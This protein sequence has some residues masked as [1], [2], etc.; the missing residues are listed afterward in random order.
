MR[1]RILA[2][3]INL[4][5]LGFLCAETGS[6]DK[7]RFFEKQV[8]PLLVKRCLKCHS[9]KKHKGSVRLDSRKFLL[10]GNESGPVVVPGKPTA[11]RMI[12]VL[13]YSKDDIQMP[14][15]G[16]LPRKEIDILRKWIQEGVYWPAHSKIEKN[17]AKSDSTDWRTHW[18]FQPVK[19]PT[20]PS[21][22][23]IGKVRTPIDRFILA[24]LERRGMIPAE[25]A[26]RATLIRRVYYD[27]IGLPPTYAQVTHFVN[28]PSPE[29]YQILIEELLSR[30]QFGERW[31]RH[32]LDLARYADTK[33]YLFRENRNYPDAYRY[34]EWVIEAF[35]SDMPYNKFLVYQLAADRVI[36]KGENRHLYAMGFLTLGRRFL[37]NIHDIID[38]R[39]DVVFRSTMGLT[40]SC[41][42]CHDHKYDPIPSADYYSLY[43]VFFSS[44]E[45][46]N[47]PCTLRLEDKPKP[48]NTRIFLRGNPGT[49]G[50][51]V[52]RQF[53]KAF[54]SGNRKPFEK[55]SGRLELAEAIVSPQNPLTARVM[56]NRV[57]GHLLG[58]PLV[59]TP[60]DFGM[61]SD[62]PSHPLLLDYLASSFVENNWSVKKLIRQIIL[63][64]VYRQRSVS[65][66]DYSQQDPE[67]RLLWKM[68]RRRLDFESHRDAL[69]LV[70]G[71]LDTSKIGGP[72]VRIE[73]APFPK[74]RS[75]YA[76]IDRQ[77]L[78]GVFRTFDFANP[79]THSPQ[80]FRTTV[81]QQSLFLMNHESILQLAETLAE[82]IETGDRKSDDRKIR[83]LYRIVLS[84]HPDPEEIRIANRFLKLSR[85]TPEK[86]DVASAWKLGWGKLDDQTQKIATFQL[87]PH[88]TGSTWQ[89][90]SK[91]PDSK[92][93]WVF[94]NAKG[95]HPGNDQSHLAIRRWIAPESGRLT[96]SGQLKHLGP[97]GD[98]VRCRIISS[99]SGK[100]GEWVSVR[101]RI[102]TR[103][104]R[105]IVQKG[106]TVD[107]VTDCRASPPSYD[108]FD[109]VVNLE[110]KTGKKT[111]RKWNSV[112]GF[113]GPVRRPL[114]VWARYAQ[115]LML[116]NEFTF[117]D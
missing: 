110:L 37:N 86:P 13:E 24:V 62:P 102:L 55:G 98:G 112:S 41:A 21:V 113:H 40:V 25:P 78:S 95:G 81:P 1:T 65:T 23:T 42:R 11:S 83:S 85:K 88:W 9:E 84:R 72:S 7:E 43:G 20:L 34:R 101:K 79:D 6:A 68:N 104:K 77:N 75:V 94:L 67:N 36:K 117:V 58:N 3:V 15:K 63:S 69:L 61:R 93:G 18:A 19:K 50:K 105:V 27:L 92:I 10:A 44:H 91:L 116:S 26:D 5:F 46:K 22:K 31:A 107:F 109:W 96:I 16:K 8:R 54:S 90:G 82:R 89:G 76:F 87:L 32:W 35:N 100:M 17:H 97:K 53:L 103:V 71:V 28:D 45:P 70:A 111:P 33:G 73:S 14:P 56:V 66:A 108:S 49:R 106:E 48:L 30:P 115:V 38:D 39:I 64:A 29:A 99:G 57:W 80:R 47:A 52:P 114:S 60:S 74:R 2:I 4:T 12:E 59:S 51:V